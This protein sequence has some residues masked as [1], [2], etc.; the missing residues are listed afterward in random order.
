MTDSKYFTTTK[1]GK[2]YIFSLLCFQK[3]NLI[4][5]RNPWG[6]GEW[7]GAW[8]EESEEYKKNLSALKKYNETLDIDEQ[9]NFEAKPEDGSFLIDFEE[10]KDLFSTLFINLD[11]PEKWTGVR[12][13]S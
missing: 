7:T 3:A 4:F 12:F 13:S 10:W 5:L 2:L 9:I 8:S 11:F 6:K 1:K